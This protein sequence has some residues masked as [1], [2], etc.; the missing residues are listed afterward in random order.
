MGRALLILLFFLAACG[1]PQATGE[2]GARRAG[3][4]DQAAAMSTG[5]VGMACGSCHAGER[6]DSGRASVPRGTC[7][8]SGCHTDGGPESVSYGTVT[9]P[10]RNHGREGE[11]LASC[12]GCH[13]HHAGEEALHVEGDACALCHL[14]AVSGKSS[15]ECRLC[16]QT[17]DHVAT[18]SQALPIPHSALPWVETGCVRCHYDVAEPRV[19]VRTARCAAC[20]ADLAAVTAAA[21]GDDLHPRHEG[22]SC[23]SCHS[24][25][26]HRVKAMSSA[27]SLVCADCHTREHGLELAIAWNDSRTC[28]SCHSAVH[29]EQQ[30]LLL[31]AVVLEDTRSSAPSS[32]FLAGVTCRSCHIRELAA[33]TAGA[34]IRGQAEACAGCHRTEY[35]RVLDWWLAGTRDRTRVMLA[36][37]GRATQDLESAPDSARALVAGARELVALVER[38]GGQHNLELADRIFRASRDRVV[39]AY[40]LAGRRAPPPPD[41]GTTAHEGLCTY[42]HYGPG[43]AGNL[44]N[45]PADFHENVMRPKAAER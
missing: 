41:L 43:G 27:V 12:A 3:E 26:A 33:D 32:K 35:R 18:T 20:H 28:N 22:V 37:T 10:H 16:H 19:K 39:R 24:P 6:A 4:S 40:T 7:M 11:V 38:A 34:A 29:Q 5:H 30:Q 31:G 15:A 36:F 21:I 42:C 25:G 44:R 17:P 13:D 9:F 14:G 23:T 8:A 2:P 1:G 45:M